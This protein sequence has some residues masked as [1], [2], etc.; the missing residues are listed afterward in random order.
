MAAGRKEGIGRVRW[1]VTTRLSTALFTFVFMIEGD[2]QISCK[3]ITYQFGVGNP[4]VL[5]SILFCIFVSSSNVNRQK[6]SSTVS[7]LCGTYKAQW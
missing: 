3:I 6:H 2:K 4:Q 7:A 1:K 5:V